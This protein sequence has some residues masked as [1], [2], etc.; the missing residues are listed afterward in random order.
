QMTGARRV[1]E[2]GSAIGYSTL[3]WAR[4]VG[5]EGAVYFTDS[6][7]LNSAEAA[8]YFH[9]AGLQH[10]IHVLEGDA[11]ALLQATPGKFD[12]IFC[13]INKD[14]YPE[15]LRQSL[16]RIK[17]GGLF[18]ADNALWSG[19]VVHAAAPGDRDTSAIQ[20]FN[21]MI[22]SDSRLFPVILPLRDG[23]AVCRV[24]PQ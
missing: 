22:Y 7:P 11:L 24:L 19:R 23:V 15:A 4:A 12:I 17:P 8:A 2:L 10:R 18:V 16:P 21:R 9:R 5:D 13:D 20:E 3:W 1:F 14:Q 6:S